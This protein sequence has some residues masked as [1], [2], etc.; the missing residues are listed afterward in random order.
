MSAF[1]IQ[2]ANFR[3]SVTEMTDTERETVSINI[4]TVVANVLPM[5]IAMRSEL[6]TVMKTGT[7]MR[8]QLQ[9]TSVNATVPSTTE[10]AGEHVLPVL[11]QN[12]TTARLVITTQLSRTIQAES[13][14]V[15]AALI[16]QDQTVDNI[17]E[18]VPIS[19]APVT[20]QQLT[21]A[22]SVL[23]MLEMIRLAETKDSVS[24]KLAGLTSVVGT[25]TNTLKTKVQTFCAHELVLTAPQ[26]QS[27]K[28]VTSVKSMPSAMRSVFV[29]VTQT[30]QATTVMT[31][32]ANVIHAVMAAPDHQTLSAQRVTNMLVPSVENVFVTM[33]QT[34]VSS[35]E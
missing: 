10:S 17:M 12:L 20:D 24:V 23:K 19:V 8:Q 6:V 16:G 31:T 3:M 13:V 33:E 25:V 22:S 18:R 30:G 5:P 1:A 9:T 28:I 7:P 26:V 29:S 34:T 27:L 35:L 15:S 2:F 14:N 11:A 21:T 4:P 32:S